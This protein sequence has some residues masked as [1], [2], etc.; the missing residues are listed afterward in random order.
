[1]DSFLPP[2]SG[3]DLHLPWHLLSNLA[4]GSTLKHHHPKQHFSPKGR[5]EEY[6]LLTPPSLQPRSHTAPTPHCAC[7][8]AAHGQGLGCGYRRVAHTQHR[9][10]LVS[11]SHRPSSTRILLCQVVP[12]SQAICTAA[13]S[14]EVSAVQGDSCTP[15]CS[16]DLYSALE[17]E[18]KAL[19]RQ[20][21]SCSQHHALVSASYCTNG[22]HTHIIYS[23]FFT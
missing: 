4:E 11:P 9:S 19:E 18:Q 14:P 6:L 2:S 1:M 5:L 22:Q 8:T 10:L 17:T 12:S 13:A 23:P 7:C 21:S 15:A 3:P 16:W 20:A